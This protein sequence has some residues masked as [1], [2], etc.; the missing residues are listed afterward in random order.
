MATPD[1]TVMGAG[2]FGLSVAWAC[3]Q[4]GARVRVIEM[5]GIGAG[6]S[7]GIV[8]ALA[9]HTPEN[10]NAKKQFQ[11]ESLLMAEGFWREVEEASGLVTGYART[12]RVQAIDSERALDLATGR[13]E[14][15]RRHWNGEAEWQVVPV[16]DLRL[17]PESATG[18][19]IHDTLSARIH[20]RMATTALAAAL[21][22]KGGEIIIGEAEPSG[23]VVWATGYEGLL[24][25]F[26][27]GQRSPGNGVKGQ[28]L[29]I[30]WDARDHPQV[31]A[32]GIHFVPHEDGTLAIGSTSERDL[33][34]Q[35]L[36]M[37]SLTRFGCGRGEFCPQ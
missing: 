5:R 13:I 35:T 34:R 29:A 36:L 17:A 1:V 4:R 26:E 24:A 21:Q 2:V 28:A 7:G 19:L 37:R 32:D 27:A 8:G 9:P 18:H 3:L 33:M 14:G 15:A 12:G 25:P 23:L 22:A 20:P 11:F 30:R 10:W 31:F 16:K 6:A